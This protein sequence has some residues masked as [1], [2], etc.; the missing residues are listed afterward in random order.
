MKALIDI[1]RTE[2]LINRIYINRMKVLIHIIRMRGLIN[3]NGMTRLTRITRSRELNHITQSKRPIHCY[4]LKRLIHCFRLKQR[5]ICRLLRL[6][7]IRISRRSAQAAM[8]R[9]RAITTL[10]Y[11]LI[12]FVP[13]VRVCQ[14]SAGRPSRPTIATCIIRILTRGEGIQRIG[15]SMR[16]ILR[17][18]ILWNQSNG[19]AV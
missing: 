19:I 8:F 17:G 13:L 10:R 4:R 18:S 7:I 1:T 12:S 9:I 11:T 2:G 15:T 16:I 6:R 14:S 5:L 3:I